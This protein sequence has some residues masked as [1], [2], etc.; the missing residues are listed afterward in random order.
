MEIPQGNSCVATFMLNKNV[1]F[2][3]LSFFYSAK[4]ENRRAKQVLP[5][6][7]GCHHWEG[8]DFVEGG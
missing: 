3:F 6:V 8:G 7:E 2:S 1:M 5:R 4:S